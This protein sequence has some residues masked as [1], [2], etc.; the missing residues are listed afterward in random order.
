M[1]AIYIDTSFPLLNAPRTAISSSSSSNSSNSF[2][3]F[4][5]YSGEIK[6]ARA[7]Y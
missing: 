7:K 2:F 1:L 5:T 3:N 4:R 6:F